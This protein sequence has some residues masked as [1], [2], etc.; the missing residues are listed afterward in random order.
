MIRINR[1]QKLY[2]IPCGDGYTCLGFDVC[3][4]KTKALHKELLKVY[5]TYKDTVL[6]KQVTRKGTYKAYF[7]YRELVELAGSINKTNGHRFTCELEPRLMGLEGKRVEVTSKD[8][9]KRRF[10]VGKSTGFIPIHLEIARKTSSGGPGVTLF[11]TDTIR[12]IS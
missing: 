1:E 11:D 7:H 4:R 8:G 6:A 9:E 5:S 2:V 12:V 10:I 3:E